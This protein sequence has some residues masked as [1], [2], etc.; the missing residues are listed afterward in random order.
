MIFNEGSLKPSTAKSYR[1][2]VEE[3]FHPGSGRSVPQAGTMSPKFHVSLRNLVHAI[4]RWACHPR[5]RYVAQNPVAGLDKLHHFER[6]QV[7]LRGGRRAHTRAAIDLPRRHH[8]AQDQ[9]SAHVVGIPRGLL[10]DLRLD[11]AT[12]TSLDDVSQRVVPADPSTACAD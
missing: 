10:D 9:G 5:R 8:V 4:A 7:A 12:M 1:S 3:H 2:M 11:A 6:A